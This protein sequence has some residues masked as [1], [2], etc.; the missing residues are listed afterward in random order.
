V[1]CHSNKTVHRLQ[2]RP[3]V[4]N[5]KAP[6]AILPSYICIRAVVWECGEGQTDR[7]THRWPRS[8]HISLWLCLTKKVIR[9]RVHSV[10]MRNSQELRREWE[11]V[12]P[13]C[14]NW[15]EVVFFLYLFWREPL[16]F[17]LS[18]VFCR[19]LFVEVA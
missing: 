4:H 3:I 11:C 13:S 6:A 14:G 16:E 5:K 9:S 10:E 1:C 19:Y 15:N 12:C 18:L 2:I 17:N 8:I 7:Q